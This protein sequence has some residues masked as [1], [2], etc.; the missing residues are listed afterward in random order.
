MTEKEFIVCMECATMIVKEL[1]VRKRN[2]HLINFDYEYIVKTASEMTL[3][4]REKLFN[5]DDK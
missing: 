4:L 5:C 2:E 3:N 1:L